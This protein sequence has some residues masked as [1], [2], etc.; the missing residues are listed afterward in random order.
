MLPAIV[1][2][3]PELKQYVGE[4]IYDYVQTFVGE[5]LAPKITGMLIDHPIEEIK[6]Y[7]YDFFELSRMIYKA[8]Q[9]LLNSGGIDP[10]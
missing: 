2:Q 7:L 6:K 8:R 5:E 1:P 10:Q 9:L 4:F 3:N